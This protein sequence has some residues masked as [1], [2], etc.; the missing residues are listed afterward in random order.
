MDKYFKI[1]MESLYEL[2]KN[3][4]FSVFINKIQNSDVGSGYR[5]KRALF[6]PYNTC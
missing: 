3:D 5:E 1:D 4:R 2:P 6:Y